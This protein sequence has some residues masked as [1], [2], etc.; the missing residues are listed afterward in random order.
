MLN[1]SIYSK[2]ITRKFI[3]HEKKF[4]I[5]ISLHLRTS[6]K[7]NHLYI[8]L[9]TL[10]S[11]LFSV[12]RS[13]RWSFRIEATAFPEISKTT[14]NTDKDKLLDNFASVV[15][16]LKRTCGSIC[17]RSASR[18]LLLGAQSRSAISAKFLPSLFPSSY[19][20]RLLQLR[21]G[22]RAE[23]NPPGSLVLCRIPE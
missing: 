21:A 23:L 16:P 10:L 11:Q 18:F 22:A 6:V 15:N 14:L 9:K 7:W 20:S 3:L 1:H 4:P 17:G 19:F 13:S 8:S 12:V 5:S 2:K